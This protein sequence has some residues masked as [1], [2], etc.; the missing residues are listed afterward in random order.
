MNVMQ[1]NSFAQGTTEYPAIIQPKVNG[2]RCVISYEN[3][4]CLMQSKRGLKYDV[5]HIANIFSQ[6]YEQMPECRDIVFDGELYIKDCFVSEIAGAVRNVKNPLHS[7]V[8]FVC[9]DLAIPNA[10]NTERDE[11]RKSLSE[12]YGFQQTTVWEHEQSK[13]SAIVWLFGIECYSDKEAEEYM[14][15]AIEHGYEGAILRNPNATYH[16]GQYTDAIVKM[17]T[18]TDEEFE[19]VDIKSNG[20]ENTPNF[21]IIY[22]L[23][24]NE[25]HLTFLSNATGSISEKTHI[26]SN[27]AAYIGRLATC[28]FYE[29]TKKRIPF[30]SN[31][32]A[33]RDYE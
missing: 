31:V 33:I 2:V 22:T 14:K 25:N 12:I 9:F 21:T 23:R 27:K 8:Q 15:T 30:H 3:G 29:R 10:T 24:N 26:L 32:V 16:F 4:K 28:K 17:K 20:K 6:F 19:I 13:A 18:Y 11:L 1:C 5:A 7:K